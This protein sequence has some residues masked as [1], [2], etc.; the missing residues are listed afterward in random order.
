M[1]IR[2]ARNCFDHRKVELKLTGFELQDD[3]SVLSP[4]IEMNF[5]GSVITRQD[6]RTYL[7]T[8]MNGLLRVIE[9]MLPYLASKH[10]Q[11]MGMIVP[12]VREVPEEKRRRKMVQFGI[13]LPFGEGGHYS[14]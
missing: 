11:P 3:G 13:W 10:I 2:R 6:L 5:A 4:T 12:Q 8:V 14:Q 9:V 7:S 1:E